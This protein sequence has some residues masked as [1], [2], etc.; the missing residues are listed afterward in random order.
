M[1]SH[2]QGNIE[3]LIDKIRSDVATGDDMIGA[4]LIK[5][6]KQTI[7][8]ILTKIINKGYQSYTFPNCMK[9]AVIKALHKKGNTED[10]SN[11]RPISILPTLSKIFERAAVDQLIA[12]LEENKLLSKNQHAYRKK[13]STVTCLVELINY[14][15]SKIDK[16]RY[17][18]IASLDLSKAFDSISHQI[19]LKKLEKLGLGRNAVKW[20][21]SYLTERKQTTKFKNF[22]SQEETVSSGIP[23]GSIVG[24]LLFLCYTNDIHEVFRNKCKVVAYADDTQIITEAKSLSELKKNIENT[25]TLAQKWYQANSMK[26]NIGKTEILVINRS[27]KNEF[28][29]VKVVDEGKQ[30]TI[31]SKPFIKVLG[32][33]IDNNLNWKKQV[34]EVKRKA[35]NSTRN[36]HR[37]NHLLPTHQRI[38]LYHA[39]ISPQFSY[40]DIVWGGCGKKEALSLQRI[41]NFAAKSIT[42]N[43]TLLQNHLEN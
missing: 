27:R 25:I 42:G 28:L 12:Y 18:A 37:I 29:K 40:A 36:I 7:S 31:E 4:K 34:N 8:P 3:K 22:K 13:H 24:P 20:I 2:F 41:Q 26:N 1:S 32:V 6:M 30:I 16:K 15:H 23:Q 11:Y 21:N 38:N 19:I 9:N 17:T 39:V 10:I 33:T 35:M 14:V 5:D 43:M